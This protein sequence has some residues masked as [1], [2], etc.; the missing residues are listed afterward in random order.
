MIR[1]E[2]SAR[3]KPLKLT[4]F[5]SILDPSFQEIVTKLVWQILQ[6][7]LATATHFKKTVLF[8]SSFIFTSSPAKVLRIFINGTSFC[9][10]F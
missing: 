3:S 9:R 5:A 2:E 10:L 6:T 7:S 1:T 8:A 4:I